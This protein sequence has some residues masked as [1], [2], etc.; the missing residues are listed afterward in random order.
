MTEESIHRAARSITAL[1]EMCGNFDK[2][3]GVPVSTTAHTTHPDDND[4]LRVSS[5]LVKNEILSVKPK[6]FHSSFRTMSVNPLSKL[7]K[8]AN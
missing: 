6:R 1:S 7:Q 3:S 2:Q 4:V 8:K 5:V